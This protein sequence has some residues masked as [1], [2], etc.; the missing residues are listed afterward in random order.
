[1]ITKWIDLLYSFSLIINSVFTKGDRVKHFLA[2]YILF[3][4][5]AKWNTWTSAILHPTLEASLLSLY[6]EWNI[7]QKLVT[8]MF[9][10]FNR[11]QLFSLLPHFLQTIYLRF[12]RR[13]WTESFS[14]FASALCLWA[15]SKEVPIRKKSQSPEIYHYSFNS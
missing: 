2:N 14:I 4:A 10:V 7:A 8:K 5:S 15:T 13:L 11:S 3:C 1:M 9:F 12:L 6:L